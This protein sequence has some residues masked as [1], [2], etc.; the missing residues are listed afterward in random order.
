MA[1]GWWQNG[2]ES[3]NVSGEPQGFRVIDI[4]S[5]QIESQ[6][7][8]LQESQSQLASWHIQAETGRYFINVFDASPETQVYIDDIGKLKPLNPFSDSAK[9]LS[10]HF[11]ELSAENIE[12]ITSKEVLSLTIVFEDGQTNWL[13]LDCPAF[14]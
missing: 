14:S 4:D 8:A 6:Y 12:Q 11:Y 7:V 9:W 5:G 10:P 1:G 3:P 13:E 2:L